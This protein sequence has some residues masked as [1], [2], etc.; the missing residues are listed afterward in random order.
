MNLASLR[1]FQLSPGRAASAAPV[2]TAWVM[3]LPRLAGDPNSP[4]ASTCGI[5]YIL[6]SQGFGISN[7]IPG[8]YLTLGHV[9][10]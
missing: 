2:E 4:K 6:R 7:M 9:E 1:K 3:Y 8:D 10:A 5:I